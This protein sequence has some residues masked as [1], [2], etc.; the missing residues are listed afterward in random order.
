MQKPRAYIETTIPNFYHETRTQP[1]LV[2]RRELTRV[3]WS[4][5]AEQYELVTGS[6]QWFSSS[7][8]QVPVIACR[9]G[10]RFYTGSKSFSQI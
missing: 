7:L 2:A 8:P 5:A 3:W 4:D 9:C 10:W 6:Y 1:E